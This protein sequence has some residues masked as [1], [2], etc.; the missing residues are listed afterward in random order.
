MIRNHALLTV[1]LPNMLAPGPTFQ[2]RGGS[3]DVVPGANS[4]LR[5]THG[6]DSARGT[7]ERF[8]PT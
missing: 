5:R 1:N 2:F 3:M 4:P 6:N 8:E 7:D